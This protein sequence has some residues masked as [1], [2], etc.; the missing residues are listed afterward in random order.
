MNNFKTVI[1]IIAISLS[2]VFSASATETNPNKTK[3]LR[4]E[5]SSF[6][7]K[8]IPVEL[9]KVTDVE[10]SFIINNE[11]EIVILSVNSEISE[12]NS[13]L[14]KK[15]N[16]KKITVKGV[17]KGEVYKMPLKINVK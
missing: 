13:Y 1:T 12:L 7:G 11:N 10:I 14:K 3:T 15:L 17:K 8:S 2:T 6:I 16:Y 5:M 9:N 4:T